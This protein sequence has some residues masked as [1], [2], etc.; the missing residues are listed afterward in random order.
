[1]PMPT[2]DDEDNEDH[3]RQTLEPPPPSLPYTPS[4]FRNR[5]SMGALRPSRAFADGAYTRGYAHGLEEARNDALDSF[6]TVL[7]R[8]LEAKFNTL[9]DNTLDRIERAEQLLM[10]RWIIRAAQATS[11]DDVFDQPG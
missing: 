9:D 11:L 3:W 7:M 6:R 10:E 8:V 4:R 5:D 2:F 1:M